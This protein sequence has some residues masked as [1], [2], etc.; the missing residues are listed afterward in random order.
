M[1][2]TKNFLKNLVFTVM[3]A[4]GFKGA[5]DWSYIEFVY[6]NYAYRG[7][8]LHINP[9]KVAESYSLVFFLGILTFIFFNNFEKPSKIAIY[10]L[11]ANLVI[12]TSSIYSLGDHSSYFMYLMVLGYLILMTTVRFFKIVN[13]IR[14]KQGTIIA[15]ILAT[16][17][18]IYVYSKLILTGGLERL[19]FN[20]MD[21]YTT[22]ADY[23]AHKNTLMGYFVTWQAYVI[24]PLVLAYSLYKRKKVIAFVVCVAQVI[25]FGMTG[26]KSFLFAPLA[27]IAVSYFLRNYGTKRLLFWVLLG[28]LIIVIVSMGIYKLFDYLI[29]PSIFIRRLFFIPAQLH[30]Q[31]YDFFSSHPKLMMSH[32]ILAPFIEYPYTLSPP[33]LIAYNYYGTIIS[34]NTGYLGD[35]YAN[36]GVMGIIIFS[37]I[38]GMVLAVFDR[39]SVV[40]P[41]ELSTSIALI[42]FM[43]LINSALFTSFVTHGILFLIVILYLLSSYQAD[44]RVSNAITNK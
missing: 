7:F 38:L 20:I 18:T 5:L 1:V 3:L 11:F 44:L 31:Y 16:G 4:I 25:L 24:N 12:P 8:D 21:V 29:F 15:C 39:V 2:F 30:F 19:N 9:V 27:I 32:S 13:I 23:V 17:I 22:R 6:P 14:L 26:F 10:V 40:L 33:Q 42:P 28:S 36:F 35:A 43:S 41:I 37:I 34:A